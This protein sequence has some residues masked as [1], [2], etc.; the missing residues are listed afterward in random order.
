MKIIF[1]N[2]KNI[3]IAFAFAFV[4]L[5]SA[6][7]AEA[8]CSMVCTATSEC[9]AGYRKYAVNDFRGLVFVCAPTWVEV[10]PWYP[11]VYVSA[12]NHPD[13]WLAS[14]P[15]PNGCQYVG[16]IG[17]DYV[18]HYCRSTGNCNEMTEVPRINTYLRSVGS[19]CTSYSWVC[20]G[21]CN[22]A[23][24]NCNFGVPANQTNLP[25]NF[26]Q[27]NTGWRWDCNG[28]GGGNNMYSC[29]EANCEATTCKGV[30]CLN[31]SGWTTGKKDCINGVCDNSTQYSCITSS[32][33]TSRGEDTT[34]T[35]WT[36]TCP[37]SN[38]GTDAINCFLVKPVTGV[39]NNDDHR[40]GKRCS[41][42]KEG[43]V[44]DTGSGWTWTC[45]GSGTGV[46][47]P[48]CSKSKCDNSNICESSNITGTAT[49]CCTYG[50][51]PKFC[52]KGK[53]LEDGDTKCGFNLSGACT[54]AE[55]G[56]NISAGTKSCYWY[57]KN[58]CFQNKSCS[59]AEIS[60]CPDP[61]TKPCPGCPLEPGEWRE[62][63]P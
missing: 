26:T 62:V 35:Q 29:T 58:S 55:C 9:P 36:W 20:N 53:K 40:D 25:N 11:G 59:A 41:S 5:A 42:G 2:T 31:P 12:W 15:R 10:Q 56:Q 44:T 8:G 21:E 47:S 6:A 46:D 50:D 7:P 60:L 16:L 37:G 22:P 39:C 63:S 27:P 24:F 30:F 34:R 48:L 28:T 57:D 33:A 17:A 43:P 14:K 23:H 19:Y 38:G 13:C 1:K 32:P 18:M 61:G 49:S 45:Y 51:E 54:L 4:C 52:L 3:I